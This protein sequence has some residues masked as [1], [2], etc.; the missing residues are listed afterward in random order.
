MASQV[1]DLGGLNQNVIARAISMAA[2]KAAASG[3]H[4]PHHHHHHHHQV[5]QAVAGVGGVVEDRTGQIVG[6]DGTPGQAVE[7]YLPAIEHSD[8][9]DDYV[10]D[11]LKTCFL[12]QDK[13]TGQVEIKLPPNTLVCPY[14]KCK[15]KKFRNRKGAF[16]HF[17]RSH[18][19]YIVHNDRRVHRAGISEEEKAQYNRMRE[20]EY[21]KANEA[22]TKLKCLT[23]NIGRRHKSLLKKI[24]KFAAMKPDMAWKELVGDWKNLLK[25]D[26]FTAFEL[27]LLRMCAPWQ[28]GVRLESRVVVTT[29]EFLHSLLPL[30]VAGE[31]SDDTL[32]W[33]STRIAAFMNSCFAWAAL[34]DPDFKIVG[35]KQVM[36]SER[37]RYNEKLTGQ[38]DTSTNAGAGGSGGGSSSHHQHNVMW[39]KSNFAVWGDYRMYMKNWVNAT[40][41]F[42]NTV[43]FMRHMNLDRLPAYEVVDSPSMHEIAAHLKDEWGQKF[44]MYDPKMPFCQV[45]RVVKWAD[46]ELERTAPQPQQRHVRIGGASGRS[47]GDRDGSTPSEHTV[48]AATAAAAAAAAAAA[49]GDVNVMQGLMDDSDAAKDH[50]S[51]EA[52]LKEHLQ[53]AMGLPEVDDSAVDPSIV[54]K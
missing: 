54:D 41:D 34:H 31:L 1:D 38:P 6:P 17:R 18:P 16:Q 29:P 7:E 5:P 27:E 22:R 10:F 8:D 20:R 25:Q 51:D 26:R 53:R 47:R 23:Y 43:E 13:N 49:S 36:A 32:N 33:Q 9:P 4:H 2:V 21:R 39:T 15:K 45:E 42:H 52:Q 48:D 12:S 24:K 40:S 28:I 35:Y 50:L 11:V 3:G 37:H 19:Q 44:R 46:E 14:I 30:R